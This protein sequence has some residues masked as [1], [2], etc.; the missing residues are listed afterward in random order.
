MVEG[1]KAAVQTEGRRLVIC[2]RCGQAPAKVRFTEVVGAQKRQR[3]LCPSCAQ[4]EGLYINVQLGGLGEAISHVAP[5][6][7]TE[8]PERS[9]E[10]EVRLR[11]EHCECTLT[12]LRRTGRVG[13]PRCYDVFFMQLAPLLDRV[14]GCSEHVGT[15][16]GE[17]EGAGE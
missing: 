17:A 16:Q 9:I 13:C 10:P 5:G 15:P 3:E 4:A 11:C 7:A 2:Q 12:Q 8:R 6:A 14:H 1:P